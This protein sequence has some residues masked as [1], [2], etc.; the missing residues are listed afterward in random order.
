MVWRVVS[1]GMEV[2]V[3]ITRFMDEDQLFLLRVHD[4]EAY[5]AVGHIRSA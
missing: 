2:N 1:R 4:G 5:T 3:Q